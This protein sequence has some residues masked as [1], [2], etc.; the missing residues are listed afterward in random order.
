VRLKVGA[1]DSEPSQVALDPSQPVSF[2][3][4]TS[5]GVIFSWLFLI[6]PSGT[7]KYILSHATA[8]VGAN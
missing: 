8:T 6:L 1:I 5:G 3:Q 4:L 7:V 2:V